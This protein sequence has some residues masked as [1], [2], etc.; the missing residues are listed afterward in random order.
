[1]TDAMDNPYVDYIC[2]DYRCVNFETKTRPVT[3]KIKMARSPDDVD[4][5]IKEQSPT[6]M[7]LDI[8]WKPMFV[9]YKSYNKASLLQLSSG[10]NVLFIQLFQVPITPVLKGV[11]ADETVKKVGVGIQSDADKMLKDWN[12]PIHGLVDIGHGMSLKK[13]AMAAIGVQ[14]TKNKKIC[15]S[16]W[17]KPILSDTQVLYAALDAWVA[18]ESFSALVHELPLSVK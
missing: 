5:W 1:M 4:A 17:E 3:M 18:S 8:E 12:T 10:D 14:L 7:G 9:P 13:V 16:N 15:R 2:K 6:I 11:L